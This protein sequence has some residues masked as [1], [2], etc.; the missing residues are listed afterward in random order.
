[1]V[2][3]SGAC[4]RNN[5]ADASLMLM[6]FASLLLSIREAM[7]TVSPTATG[8]DVRV[9]VS[10]NAEQIHQAYIGNSADFWIPDNTIVSKRRR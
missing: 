6:R 7:L 3:I 9:R 8:L 10:I 2:G 4:L 1:M 5:R